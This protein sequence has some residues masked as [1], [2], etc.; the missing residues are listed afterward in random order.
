E[1]YAI[2]WLA[3][4]L[5]VLVLAVWTGLLSTLASAA[6]ITYLPSALFAVSFLFVLVMLVHFSLTISRLSD[7]NTILAQR[8][9]LLQ[10]RLDRD[11]G[12]ELDGDARGSEEAALARSAGGPSHPPGRSSRSRGIIP[13]RPRPAP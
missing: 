10:E 9:A 2:L 1:R 6:G 7:Q 11:L 8:L 12:E 4:G 5:T 13:A 3:A